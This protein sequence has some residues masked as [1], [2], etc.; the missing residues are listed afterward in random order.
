MKAFWFLLCFLSARS[1]PQNPH[2]SRARGAGEKKLDSNE[3]NES[4]KNEII[5]MKLIVLL[6]AGINCGRER[7]FCAFL[8]PSL[9][10]AGGS[11]AWR[12]MPPSPSAR[13][14]A[15]GRLV[16]D[17]ETSHECKE[18]GSKG[19]AIA[20][21]PRVVLGTCELGQQSAV[22]CRAVPCRATCSLPSAPTPGW[23]CARNRRG[24]SQ[25]GC[26][27]HQQPVQLLPCVS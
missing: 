14:R 1:L 3:F 27:C 5:K 20:R 21:D 12:R 9:L 13:K 25:N 16:A 8:A 23:V 17:V 6:T 2:F 22:P 7:R 26:S 19:S 4:Y 11:A 18:K 24:S 10:L 15:G